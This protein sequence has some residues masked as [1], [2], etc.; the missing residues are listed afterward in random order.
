MG[1]QNSK[2]YMVPGLTFRHLAQ[3]WKNSYHDLGERCD[4]VASV[5]NTR[6]QEILARY[7]QERVE[8]LIAHE[9]DE[10]VPCFGSPED[11][12]WLKAKVNSAS[13]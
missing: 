10:L 13:K 4:Q 8:Q 6:F 3:A 2:F 9:D 1:Q 5:E 7:P 11:F 12:A